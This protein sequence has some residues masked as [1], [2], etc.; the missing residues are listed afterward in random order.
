MGIWQSID[1]PRLDA[2]VS[3]STWQTFLGL[4]PQRPTAGGSEEDMIE[5]PG[6]QEVRLPNAEY[7]A[8]LPLT[9]SE[10]LMCRNHMP[11]STTD[12]RFL[13]W[14]FSCHAG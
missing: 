10:Q 12:G 14:D 6:H 7:P 5:T 8:G 13:R 3:R 1:V 2:K 9:E 11:K 4:Q